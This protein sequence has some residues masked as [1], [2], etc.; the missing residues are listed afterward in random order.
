MAGNIENIK[1]VDDVKSL[2]KILNDSLQKTASDSERYVMGEISD[3]LKGLEE[4][5]IT[6]YATNLRDA[7]IKRLAKLS[8]DEAASENAIWAQRIAQLNDLLAKKKAADSLYRPFIG[9]IQTLSKML[10]KKS[11]SG[12]QGAINFLSI[13]LSPEQLAKR[14]FQKGN[15]EMADF[16]SK[17]FEDEWSL[18]KQYQR[19]DLRD[20]SITDRTGKF[21]TRMFLKKVNG[22]EPEIQKLL[23]SPDELTKINAARTYLRSIPEDFNPSHT[24]HAGAI[25]HFF[26]SPVSAAMANAHD[27]GI[28]MYLKSAVKLPPGIRPNAIETGAQLGERF[29]K[30]NATRD[31]VSRTENKVATAAKAIFTTG[32]GRGALLSAGT[33]AIHSSYTERANRIA[34]LASNPDI[35]GQHLSNAVEGMNEALPNVSQSMQHA[36]MASVM[37]LNSKLPRPQ[38]Q[39]MLSKDWEP[40]QLQKQKFDKYYDAVNNPTSVLQQIKNASLSGEAIEAVQATHPELFKE[41]QTKVLGEMDQ[42]KA[43]KL[44]YGVRLSLAKFLGQPLDSS[45]LPKVIMANQVALSSPGSP[46]GMSPKQQRSTQ[47]GLAKLKV[48][49]RAKTETQG[50]EEDQS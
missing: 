48:A 40:S 9:K 8:P 49:S 37:F 18:V 50:L 46:N 3:R 22:L 34:Q 4:R 43:R 7:H 27:F 35:L 11:V 29:N 38:S 42:D 2:R 24:S 15:S 12:A 20:S 16:F 13:D 33:Q 39:F 36:M 14:A 19:A 5:T 31:V 21:N 25:R 1:S 32:S 45:M 30:L 10:G 26:E 23:F 17:N 41:M 6:N 44:S 28:D 47:S